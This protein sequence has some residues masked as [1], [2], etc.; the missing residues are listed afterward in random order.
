MTRFP[1]DRFVKDYLRELLLPFGEVETSKKVAGETREIDVQFT[2]TLQ[3]IENQQL[4]LLLGQFATTPAL[5]EPFRN[6]ATV[7]EIRSCVSKLFDVFSQLERDS[8]TNKTR[9]VEAD[10]P[11]L[12]ILS[13]TISKSQLYGFRAKLD[14]NGLPGI[15]FF[16]DYWRAA[17]IAIHQLPSTPETLW[18]RL[19]GRGKVQQRAITELKA[20]PVNHPLRSVAIELLANLKTTLE[21]SK[22]LNK[23]ER[24][25]IMKLS[26]IYEEQLLKARDEG[27]Q[28]G[29]QRGQRAVVEGLLCSRFG[30][31]DEQ[32]A[33][34][35]DSILV[36]P[37]EESMPMLLNSSR[38][39]LLARFN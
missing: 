15:Y 3:P 11:R 30:V 31:L 37:S 16:G 39:E 35:I 2:P 12:W 21:A 36:L 20:L 19:L 14:D 1:Y 24:D 13:P 26:P 27:I 10:L 23:E 5:F 8:K 22:K 17:V 28:Q 33:A 18:L 38:E 9:I 25:L 7:D 32:L 29:I 4:L 34:I 6:A